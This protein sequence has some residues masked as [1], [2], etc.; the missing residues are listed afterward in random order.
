MLKNPPILANKAFFTGAA[1][2]FYYYSSSIFFS[3]SAV[4]FYVVAESPI[5]SLKFGSTSS[6]FTL[7]GDDSSLPSSFGTLVYSD[8]DYFAALVKLSDDS[9]SAYGF[10]TGLNSLI[11]ILSLS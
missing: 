6:V 2:F 4:I 3:F 7:S 5:L 9:N 1:A 11:S 8:S 10:F